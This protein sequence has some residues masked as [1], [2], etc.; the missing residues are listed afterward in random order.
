ME[1]IKKAE[2]ARGIRVLI[3]VDLRVFLEN[4][5]GRTGMTQ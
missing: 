2:A 5:C 1:R 3:V 4:T